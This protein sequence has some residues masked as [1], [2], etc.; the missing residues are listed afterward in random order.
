MTDDERA[1]I[2]ASV[3]RAWIWLSAER[4]GIAKVHRR[5]SSLPDFERDCFLEPLA[6]GPTRTFQTA[7]AKQQLHQAIDR[8][9]FDFFIRLGE[10]LKKPAR[11]EC[12]YGE[13]ATRLQRFLIEH[14]IEQKDGL[15]ELCRLTPDGL[16]TVC[17]EVLKTRTITGATV[18]KTR[19]RMTLLPFKR[20][21]ISV[22]LSTRPLRFLDKNGRRLYFNNQTKSSP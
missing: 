5:K 1:Q 17:R 4:L 22:P 13:V 2:Q 20:E 19:R 10:V 21:K 3:Q 12:T 8:D 7:H 16:A 6:Y 18:E 11:P 14:W 15:P 9:D